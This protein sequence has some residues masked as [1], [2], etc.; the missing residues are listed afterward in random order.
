MNFKSNILFLA[1]VIAYPV[2]ALSSLISEV[3]DDPPQEWY[4]YLILIPMFPISLFF[5]LYPPIFLRGRLLERGMPKDKADSLSFSG[6]MLY[7]V[8]WLII[9]KFI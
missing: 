3:V 4:E 6:W 8:F 7:V 2:I 1:A 5:F 9:S